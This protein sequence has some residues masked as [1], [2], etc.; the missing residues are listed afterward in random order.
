[1]KPHE[2]SGSN[3]FFRFGD[4]VHRC[5]DGRSDVVDQVVRM[6]YRVAHGFMCRGFCTAGC[7]CMGAF[8]YG[9]CERLMIF[10]TAFLAYFLYV[11]LKATQQRQV[12]A[13]QY[14]RM[15]VVSLGMAACEVFIFG[16]ISIHAVAG[17]IP[18][19]IGLTLCIGLGGGLGSVTGTWLHAREARNG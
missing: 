16:A 4:P 6:A 7:R 18:A 5:R 13:A 9:S 17:D 3:G 15:P 12:M 10:A 19:L 1:M 14:V 11:A 2:H 8:D